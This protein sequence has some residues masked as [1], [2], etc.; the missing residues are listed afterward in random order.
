MRTI[1]RTAVLAAVL[2]LVTPGAALAGSRGGAAPITGWIDVALK[3][4]SGHRVNPP[5]A[6]RALALV[7]V[8]MR[9]G[10][11]EGKASVHGAAAEV[12]GY[13]FPD[14]AAAFDA[15]AAELGRG[16]ARLRRGRAIGAKVVERARR[17]NSDAVYDGVRLVGTGYWTEPP[18]VA[19]PLEPAA[20]R[21]LPWSIASGAAMRPPPPPG[22]DDP[23]YAEQA[24][25]VYETSRSLTPE[26]RAIALFWADGAGTETPPGHWNRIAIELVEAAHLSYRRAARTFALLNKAQADAFIAAWDAKFAYWSERPDQAI[27]RAIDPDWSP[28]IPTPP[29]PGYVSGHSTTS[30]AASTVLGALFPRRSR[31]L[32][33]LA[34]QAALSRLYGGIHFSVDNGAGLALGRRVGRA[35]LARQRAA[36]AR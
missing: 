33:A 8:A 32:A 35:A 17:D 26:Q 21:W 22:P 25:E 30:G 36:H 34:R 12:L 16:A 31:K 19:G 20:G 2:S 29:V 7:S 28:L 27:R 4:I 18:G 6:S 3:E 9:R 10:S 13:L 1:V 11:A 24:M 15:R 23:G 14:R 5:R